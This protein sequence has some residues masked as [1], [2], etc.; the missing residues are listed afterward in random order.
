[1]K[2]FILTGIDEG[3]RNGLTSFHDMDVSPR[4]LKILQE[5]DRENKLKAKIYTYLSAQFDD[6]KTIRNLNYTG[7]NLFIKGIKLYMDGALGSRG[8]AL[9]QPYSDMP[10]NYGLLSFSENELYEK[11][12]TGIKTGLDCAIHAIGDRANNTVINAYKKIRKNFPGNQSKLRIEHAQNISNDDLTIFRDNNIIASV[13][14]IHCISDIEMAEKR[15]GKTRCK[16]ISYKW[17]SFLDLEFNCQPVLIF[18][19]NLIIHF[20]VLMPS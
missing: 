3:I 20:S 2:N 16:N 15:L 11:I 10:S 8:A 12:Q 19:S 6:Y 14:P 7:K 17:K 1:M 13:Q 4:H 5:L 9:F 18:L